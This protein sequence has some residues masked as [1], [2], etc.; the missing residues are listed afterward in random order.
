MEA[1]AIAY[2]ANYAQCRIQD[3]DR[4]SGKKWR[5]PSWSG[6]ESVTRDHRTPEGGTASAGFC[7]ARRTFESARRYSETAA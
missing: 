4:V 6:S 1:Q 2:T 7:A 5:S 3:F